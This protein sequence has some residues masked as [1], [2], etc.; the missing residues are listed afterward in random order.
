MKNSNFEHSWPYKVPGIPDECFQRGEGIPMTRS[1]I[2][3]LVISRLRIFEGA[4]VYDVGAGSGSVA[5]E[6]A[7]QGGQVYAVEKNREALD[8]I[9][10]NAIN[11]GVSLEIV[12]GEAPQAIADLPYPHRVFIGG[13][14]GNL[15]RILDSCHERL[16]SG[17]RLVFTSVTID[18]VPVVYH[19]LKSRGYQVDAVQLQMAEASP[20]GNNVIWKGQNP[21]TIISGEKGGEG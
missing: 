11:F 9:K 5:V 18:P 17:G 3:T 21:V 20:T 4:I 19:F 2:R 7:L 15:E 13:S 12:A 6:C 1:E 16:I 8:L 10:Q 14:G